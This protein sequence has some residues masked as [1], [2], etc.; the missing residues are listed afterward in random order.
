M[1]S[2]KHLAHYVPVLLATLLAAGCDQMQQD[3]IGNQ[4]RNEPSQN[5]QPS[6]LAAADANRLLEREP[7]AAGQPSS[8]EPAGKEPAAPSAS[9][10]SNDMALDN[11][12]TSAINQD[13]VLK[14]EHIDVT[15]QSGIVTL[16]GTVESN[17]V[18]ERA[19]TVAQGVS[20]VKAVK[21]QLTASVTPK[22]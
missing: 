15:V 11:L 7:T 5:E 14:S 8:A 17:V 4:A 1:Q 16:A 2:T 10:L 12:V 22:G 18:R 6:D 21:N 19:A 9:Q 3:S 13:G 20:G